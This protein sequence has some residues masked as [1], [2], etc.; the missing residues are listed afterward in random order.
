MGL[1]TG[2]Y[3]KE[4]PIPAN[5]N[6]FEVSIDELEPLTDAMRRI[7]EQ[8]NVS[9]SS[10]ALNYVICKGVIP[11]GGA[12]DAK[13]AEE[14]AGALGWRLTKEEITELESYHVNRK[15]P[16]MVRFWQHG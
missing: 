6:F 10:V 4:N 14:N 5:R 11:I 15:I 16:F 7:G 9:V 1:L 3:S 13:Q 8:H 2:K 12:R